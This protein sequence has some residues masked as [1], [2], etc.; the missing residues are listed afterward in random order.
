[1]KS[2]VGQGHYVQPLED[3]PRWSEWTSCREPVGT[4]V[5]LSSFRVLETRDFM[6][7]AHVSTVMFVRDSNSIDCHITYIESLAT[8]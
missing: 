8:F 4:T 2:F 1:M 5:P 6:V 7:T 3:W